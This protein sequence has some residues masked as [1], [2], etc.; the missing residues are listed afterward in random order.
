MGIVCQLVF[1]IWSPTLRPYQV[2]N[3]CSFGNVSGGR[4]YDSAD[5]AASQTQARSWESSVTFAK[6][7]ICRRDHE[8]LVFSRQREMDMQNRLAP[9]RLPRKSGCFCRRRVQQLKLRSGLYGNT[10]TIRS[11]MLLFLPSPTHKQISLSQAQQQPSTS[12]LA[13][14]PHDRFPFARDVRR[15]AMALRNGRNRHSSSPRS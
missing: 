2:S 3:A 14:A 9:Q 12:T 7:W 6:A 11:T 5:L 15:N 4:R 8:G 1:A 13:S 10:A